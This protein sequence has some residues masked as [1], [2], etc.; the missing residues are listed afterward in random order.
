MSRSKKITISNNKKSPFLINDSLT[1]ADLAIFD[2]L[3]TLDP[4]ASHWTDDSVFF[5]IKEPLGP[6]QPPQDIF[7]NYLQLEALKTIISQTP[8]IAAWMSSHPA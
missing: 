2:L 8:Q 3:D 7:K 5:Y 6:F 1:W 4:N